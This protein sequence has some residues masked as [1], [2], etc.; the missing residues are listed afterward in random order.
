MPY[1]FKV[2]LIVVAILICICTFFASEIWL[3]LD[4]IER[5]QKER[6]ERR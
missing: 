2:V 3:L 5:R 4:S 1:L 6:D